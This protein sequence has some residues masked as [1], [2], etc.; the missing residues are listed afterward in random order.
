MQEVDLGGN[1]KLSECVPLIL[2]A[3]T[4]KN[5]NTLVLCDMIRDHQL[6]EMGPILQ[7]NNTLRC[8]GGN[9]LVIIIHKRT[10]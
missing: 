2:T 7:S 3:V 10:Q 8:W 1:I 4:Y 6:L 9:Q 5:I